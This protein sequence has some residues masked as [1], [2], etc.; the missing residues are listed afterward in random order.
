MTTHAHMWT[1]LLALFSLLGVCAIGLLLFLAL[2]EGVVVRRLL[3]P[4]ML[5]IGVGT[6]AC[7]AVLLLLTF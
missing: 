1:D 7:V 3:I 6:C 2:V 4:L 5:M